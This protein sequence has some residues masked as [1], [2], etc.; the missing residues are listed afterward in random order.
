MIT[1]VFLKST[2]RPCASVSRPSSRI[3]SRMLN[4]SGCAFSISSKST[5]EY[6]LRRDLLGELARLVVA[7]VAR[8][9]ADE[10]RR[11]CAAPGTRSCRSG[12]S[13]P[14]SPNSASASARRA[15]SCRRRSGRGR[16]SC[17]SAGAGRRGRRGTG[18]P[19]RRRRVDR[20]VLADD[21]LVQ[22]LLELQQALALLGRELRDRDAGGAGDDLRD[23]LRRD[24]RRALAL[25]RLSVDARPAAR[26]DLVLELTGALV[27]LRRRRLV[28]L[29]REPP[30]VLLERRACRRPSS[31]CAA[32]RAR[33]P[34]RSG[35]S[36]CRAGSGR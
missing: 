16:G 30:E 10:P 3:C 4:T 14:R 17:R 25:L 7:D 5:T 20:L 35:R 18:A 6:G 15:R 34:G 8:R 24:L 13:G 2:V 36:P 9:G 12:P 11:P 29:A 32:G 33:R 21:A 31:S 23:V 19:P 28:A 26:L 1:T 22:L 27:V